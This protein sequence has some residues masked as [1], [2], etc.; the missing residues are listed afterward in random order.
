MGEKGTHLS[1]DCKT[2]SEALTF[3]ILSIFGATL[4]YSYFNNGK[5]QRQSSCL[6]ALYK[7]ASKGW[8]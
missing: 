1:T 3:C 5:L 6:E 7:I 8:Q 2:A 4:I